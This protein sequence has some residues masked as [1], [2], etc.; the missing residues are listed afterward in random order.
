MEKTTL[1]TCSEL[2][3]WFKQYAK[4]QN[5][6]VFR[7]QADNNW[8]LQTSLAR[9]L[10]DH[11]VASNEWRKRELKM[12]CEFRESLL[13][14]CPGIYEDWPAQE[15][16]SLMQHHGA[17]TR[18]L[19]FSYDPKVAA[20]FSLESSRGDSAIWV[21]DRNHLDQRRNELG[22]GTFDYCGPKHDPYDVFHKDEEGKYLLVGSIL[23]PKKPHARLAAQRGCFLVP[24]SISKEIDYELVY[25]KVELSRALVVESLKQLEHEGFDRPYL[26]PDLDRLAQ[27]AKR[28]SVLGGPDYRFTILKQQDGTHGCIPACAAS[29][30][31]YH[32]IPKSDWSEAGLLAMYLHPLG[33]GFDT[34]KQYLDQQ[35]E[36][37]NDWEVVIDSC[38][39]P[40]LQGIASA[41]V[42]KH[43]PAL[44]P[45][46]QGAGNAAH[47]VVLI[48]PDDKGAV[49]CD[50][51][52]NQ[53][54]RQV[55]TWSQIEDIWAGGLL[56]L[57]KKTG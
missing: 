28:S 25:A 54:D 17:P 4:N 33:T 7:G 43:G 10:V 24:G 12:Y 48:E 41:V 31:R 47:C 23:T 6:F 3:K 19:D 1:Q 16:L 42:G 9:Y 15:I 52:P 20:Y 56:Y 44:I 29:L 50:P 14:A 53:P 39:G 27:R 18:M 36:I 22:L 57:R 11:H 26:F 49:I 34:L 38:S 8:P 32:A 46:N 55:M 45:L 51:S 35:P 2:Q 21:V 40:D 5:Q 30:L 13:L 37:L